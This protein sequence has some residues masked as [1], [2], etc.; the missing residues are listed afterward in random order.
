MGFAV[1]INTV[2][3]N[4]YYIISS[5]VQAPSNGGAFLRRWGGLTRGWCVPSL[6]NTGLTLRLVQ[7]QINS[8][9]RPLGHHLDPQS[10]PTSTLVNFQ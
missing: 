2:T 8:I 1:L 4:R 7:Y 9:V 10:P 6:H 3:H 5:Q